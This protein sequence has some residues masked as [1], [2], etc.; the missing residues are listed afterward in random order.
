MITNWSMRINL[1]DNNIGQ[2][3]AG[4][5]LRK[6]VSALFP[7]ADKTIAQLCHENENLLI[8][9]YSIEDSDDK[10]GEASVMT[11][12]NTSDPEKV[13]ITTGNVMGFIG[14]GNLQI[15]IK[16]RFDEGRDD[17]L[18]HYML[19]R[20]FHSISLTLITTTKKRMY[21]TL[22]CLCSLTC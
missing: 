20:S 9:P 15:K 16:S 13:R 3:K 8:F 18:L 11:I 6:D 14:V 4:I 2:V 21:L 22:S 7:I 19:K 5:F 1:T 17:Y 10:V 12:L